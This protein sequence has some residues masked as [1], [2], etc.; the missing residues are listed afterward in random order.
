MIDYAVVQLN[1]LREQP[2][3]IVESVEEDFE[4]AEISWKST[5]IQKSRMMSKPG[6]TQL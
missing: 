2:E 3:K 4:P 1:M 6:M 5:R